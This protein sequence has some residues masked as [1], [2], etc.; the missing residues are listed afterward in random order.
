[1][2]RLPPHMIADLCSER[3]ASVPGIPSHSALPMEAALVLLA[4]MQALIPMPISPQSSSL[5][6]DPTSF[7]PTPSD[8]APLLSLLSLLNDLDINICPLDIR[9]A[10][11]F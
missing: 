3:L 5:T 7:E 4:L 10:D 6:I 1:M 9:E 11:I 2:F 8:T